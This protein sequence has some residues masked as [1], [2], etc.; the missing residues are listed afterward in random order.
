MPL[1]YA[2]C[3]GTTLYICILIVKMKSCNKK[4]IIPGSHRM[5]HFTSFPKVCKRFIH[6]DIIDAHCIS[7]ELSYQRMTNKPYISVIKV[8]IYIFG[9][10]Y[11]IHIGILYWWN[12][13]NLIRKHHFFCF[14]YVHNII[15]VKQWLKHD[16]LNII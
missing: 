16:F 6:L 14:Y 15:N 3:K 5:F 1:S 9:Y 2:H 12:N 8:G 10:I 4:V 11:I 13:K 7:L